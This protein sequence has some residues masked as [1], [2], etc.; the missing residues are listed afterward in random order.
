MFGIQRFGST[1]V[2]KSKRGADRVSKF[3]A[4]LDSHEAPTNQSNN[5]NQHHDNNYKPSNWKSSDEVTDHSLLSNQQNAD[6]SIE[7]PPAKRRKLLSDVTSTNKNNSN[8]N[9][10]HISVVQDSH[11]HE[12]EEIKNNTVCVKFLYSW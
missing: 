12:I 9:N 7:Q 2:Q 10:D 6:V 11:N 1:K 8:N 4:K 3:L 5:R